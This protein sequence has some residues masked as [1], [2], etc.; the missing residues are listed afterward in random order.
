[1]KKI[2]K[3]FLWLAYAILI[4]FLGILFLT[5]HIPMPVKMI[6]TE[7]VEKAERL[8]DIGIVTE[9]NGIEGKNPLEVEYY[10][11]T[12]QIE[13]LE[14]TLEECQTK[15]AREEEVK[16]ANLHEYGKQV[17]K[18][19]EK[20]QPLMNY[21]VKNFEAQYDTGGSK[22]IQDTNQAIYAIGELSKYTPWGITV[23]L[24]SSM[25]LDNSAANY[26]AM[27]NANNA[28]GTGMQTIIVDTRAE[29]EKFVARMDFYEKL[30]EDS[31]ND[32]FTRF[33]E[34]RL[35]TIWENQYLMKYTLNGKE[36]GLE[37]YADEVCKKLY[38]MGAATLTLEDHYKTLLTDCDSKSNSL[39]KLENQYK[40]I[41]EVV[42]YDGEGRIEEMVTTEELMHYLAPLINAGRQAANGYAQLSTASPLVDS[43]FK[44]TKMGRVYWHFKEEI[45]M[46]NNDTVHIYYAGGK[47][48][49]VNGY[50]FYAGQ[51]LN[52]D[53]SE[54]AEILYNEAM[55]LK[56]G[57]RFDKRDCEYHMQKVM[58][59][60]GNR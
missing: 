3:D 6:S 31:D 12:N 30:T 24:F 2:N 14:K 42:N 37:L 20:Y 27:V 28:F 35:R 43:T 56:S 29:M 51:L 8:K 10:E 58:D 18:I 45:T 57:Y 23:N 36:T 5:G 53:G 15:L 47:P 55:W 21:N 17:E 25:A 52:G 26:E 34:E 39:N 1:M 48:T 59:A 32:S 7:P 38:I 54:D 44:Y 49:Y 33:T 9:N 19:K 46:F 40:E 22:E 41:M 16:F 13:E 60:C 4:S 50:Y 11:L